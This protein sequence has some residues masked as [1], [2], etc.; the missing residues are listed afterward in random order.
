MLCDEIIR[1]GRSRVPINPY[2]RAYL[3]RFADLVSKAERFV[4]DDEAI[5][6]VLNV[7]E[8][9]P[10]ALLAGI[11]I[12]RLPFPLMWLEYN[13]LYRLKQQIPYGYPL[14]AEYAER[15]IRRLRGGMLI[16]ATDDSMQ[17]G[18]IICCGQNEGDAPLI[19]P[20][21]YQFDWTEDFQNTVRRLYYETYTLRFGPRGTLDVHP[22][23]G[24]DMRSKLTDNAYTRR[25]INDPRE[26]K[27]LG[28][29]EE[30]YRYAIAKDS[31]DWLYSLGGRLPPG[32]V[33]EMLRNFCH[34]YSGE[35]RWLL[36]L[37]LMLNSRNLTEMVPRSVRELNHQ[38]SPRVLPVLVSHSVIKI[39]LTRVGQ[40]RA[41]AHG[42]T[43]GDMPWH[44]VRGHWKV[45]KTG[46][47]FWR[48][49]HRGDMTHGVKV[50]EYQISR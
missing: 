19:N 13:L 22:P 39:K 50:H 41:E 48:P 35:K 43:A 8:S 29:I 21:Q 37:M 9:K 33:V 46:V 4:L 1:E 31:G 23:P 7:E 2:E 42:V 27:A 49:H 36:G 10:S 47:F 34:D 3:S 14:Q 40:N 24:A 44:K 16:E 6:V 5:D 20:V 18:Q 30:R 26:V 15:K 12:C 38:R 25:I 32:K 11:N 45:R 28:A 17:R